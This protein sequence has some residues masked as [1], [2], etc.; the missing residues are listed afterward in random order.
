VS[1]F[2]ACVLSENFRAVRFALQLDRV[3]QERSPAP[4]ACF[5][6]SSEIFGLL[7]GW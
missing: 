1:E 3:C 4:K 5:G 2:G 6:G 7:G